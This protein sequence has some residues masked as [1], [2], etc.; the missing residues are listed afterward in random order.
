MSSPSEA[1][2]DRPVRDGVIHDLGYRGYTGPRLT[3]PEVAR[4]FFVSGLRHTYG[5]GRSAKSKVLPMI[6]LAMILLPALILVGVLVQA[7]DLLGLDEQL[8]AYSTYPITTLLLISV[9]VAAQ[10]P[11]LVSRDLRFRTITLYL[12]RPMA[13]RT[14]VLVRLGS[15]TAAVFLLIAAPLLLMYVGGLL[16]DLPFWRETGR[17]LVGLL[18]ALL[19]AACLAGPAALVAALTVRRGLAVAGVIVVL[20][21]SYTVVSGVQGI[22]EAS[23][24]DK[25]GEVAGVFSP[26][27]LVNGLQVALLDAPRSTLTPPEGALMAGLYVVALVALVGGSTA[28]LLA[29]FRRVG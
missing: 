21:V 28:A 10:A 5:L 17:F 16:A 4:A 13:R 24:H 7:K 11:A 12:A 26:Y 3:G 14:Y 1:P 18:G 23:G 2:A 6:L 8:V 22:A 25:V 19:L 29:R 20:L 9:F 27:T 15:L